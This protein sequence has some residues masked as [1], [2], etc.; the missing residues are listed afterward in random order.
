MKAM[1]YN[2]GA[3]VHIEVEVS[4]AEDAFVSMTCYASGPRVVLYDVTAED[5]QALKD[6]CDEALR[7]LGVQAGSDNGQG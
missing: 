4:N 1:G 6:A 5:A 7:L 3:Q 2:V